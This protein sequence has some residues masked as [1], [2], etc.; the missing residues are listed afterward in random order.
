MDTKTAFPDKTKKMQELILY[1]S[2]QLSDDPKF[3][4]TKLNK[5]LFFA[6]FLRY[7][8]VR[9]SITGQQY[10]KLPNGPAPKTLI[11]VREEMIRQG[12][13]EIQL[14]DYWGLKQKV[15]VAKRNPDLTLFEMSEIAL[16]DFIIERLRPLD[17]NECSL[18]SH[19]YL[20]LFWDLAEPQETIPYSMA[21]VTHA[22]DDTPEQMEYNDEMQRRAEKWL[23]AT[24]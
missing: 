16:V 7:T 18:K 19:Q 22:T 14:R 2:E 23:M 6:D 1:I 20:E 4:S 9:Q 15:P 21:L 24:T 5:I 10:W 12:F 8:I 13:L 11:P 17:A 3:G